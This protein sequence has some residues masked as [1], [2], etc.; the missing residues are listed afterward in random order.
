M[1]I[2]VER[3]VSDNDTTI[4]LIFING[5]FTCFGL[6]EE[7]RKDKVPAET[8]IPAGNYRVGLRTVGD[9]HARYSRK[10]PGL[11]RGML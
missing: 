8:R 9:F 6:E 10:F 7:Y 11:H 5:G 3:I 2:T 1:K 4:S